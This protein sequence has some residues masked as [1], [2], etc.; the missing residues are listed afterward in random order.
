[1]GKSKKKPSP[2]NKKP[3][4]G[5]GGNPPAR[6]F[7]EPDWSPDETKFQVNN[8]SVQYYGSPYYKLH[9]STLQSIPPP[10]AGAALQVQLADIIG[11]A[12]VNA[13]QQSGRIVFHA[14]GDTG[15]AK[16]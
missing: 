10:R 11:Q 15:A 1:M 12:Q 13:I 2:G 7:G 3:V 9:K 6:L 4:K 5:K 8:T 16:K 14:A